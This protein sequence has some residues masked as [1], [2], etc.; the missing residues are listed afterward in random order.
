MVPMPARRHKTVQA[1][2]GTIRRHGLVPAGA[3]VL[4][5][6][7]GGPDSVALASILR[8][9][10]GVRRGGFRLTLAHLDHRLRAAAARDRRFVAELARRWDLP[11]VSGRRDVRALARR[12]GVGIEEAARMARYDF[13]NRAARKAGAGIVAVGHHA[14]DQ[15]ETVLMNLLRGSGLRGLAGMPI[16]RP[17]APG[18]EVTL[19]RPLLEVRRAEVV[20]YLEARGLEW[21]EDET[22]RSR[23]MLRN[24]VRLDLLPMLERDYAPG[25]AA[26]LAR[27]AEGLRAVQQL[28][29]GRAAAAW[30]GAVAVATARSIEFR[31]D[32]LAGEGCAVASEMFLAAMEQLGAGRGN[33]TAAHL[34]RLWQVIIAGR[35]GQRVELPGRVRAVRSGRRLRL[36]RST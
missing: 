2:A 1:V 5:A 35:G 28:V 12:R 19:V 31:L 4:A 21:M 33:L 26:R 11:V 14:D 25:F 32:A 16:R 36:T 23:R 9:L 6:A 8:E 7:S 15:A 3:H 30:D 13:L 34:G 27:S 10:S 20:D 29:A 17:L 24:R 22:N 18:S